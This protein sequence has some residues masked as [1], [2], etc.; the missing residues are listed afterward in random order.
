[1]VVGLGAHGQHGLGDV[2]DRDEP[3]VTEELSNERVKLLSCGDRRSFA[4]TE[5][6]MV[7]ISSSHSASM[8]QLLHY[9]VSPSHSICLSENARAHRA[10]HGR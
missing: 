9:P 8:Y 6:D 3:T 4:V 2:K 5:A 1:M 7:V 10:H